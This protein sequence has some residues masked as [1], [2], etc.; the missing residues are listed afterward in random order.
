[1]PYYIKNGFRVRVLPPGG[2]GDREANKKL[3][4]ADN[5][6][7]I[8]L[9][10]KRLEVTVIENDR[11]FSRKARS[12]RKKLEL[13]ISRISKELTSVLQVQKTARERVKQ[14]SRLSF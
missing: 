6:R 9:I 1:M 8:H 10:S 5:D 4:L 2:H 7:K 12:K 14:Y 11:S 3:E 13:K